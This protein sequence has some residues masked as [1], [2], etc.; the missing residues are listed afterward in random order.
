MAQSAA[1]D[2][3]CQLQRQ[4]SPRHFLFLLVEEQSLRI[5]VSQALPP[6]ALSIRRLTKRFGGVVAL[7]GCSFDVAQGTVTGLIG[8]NGAGKSTLFHVVSGFAQPDSGQVLLQGRD[9][10]GIP[11]HKL[12]HMGLVRTFQIPHEFRKLTVQESLMMVPG[13]Q[14]GEGITALWTQWREVQKEEKELQTRADE[15]LEILQMTHMRDEYAGNLSGGQKKLL[16]LGRTMMS[17]A[18]VILLDEPG[19]GVNPTLMVQLQKSIRVL[20]QQQGYTFCIIEHDMDLI[21]K[22][23]DPV[24]VMEAGNVLAQGSMDEVRADPEVVE[25]YLSRTKTKLMPYDASS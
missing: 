18:R 12:F 13:K 25:A 16:E 23:C 9:I 6:P 11:P 3:V 5:P 17:E 2:V 14:L 10:T 24:I 8:P 4:L 19:A 22:L 15:V 1:P 21:A 20:N 7:D